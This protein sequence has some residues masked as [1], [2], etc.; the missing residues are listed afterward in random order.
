MDKSSW[1]TVGTTMRVSNRVTGKPVVSAYALS[2][3]TGP[4]KE[5]EVVLESAS[6]GIWICDAQ[7]RVLKVNPASEWLKNVRASQVVNR[8]MH[9]LLAEGY[10]DRSVTLEVLENRSRIEMLQTT[11]DG[12]R[13]SVI[14]IPVYDAHGNLFR[15]VSIEKDITEIHLLSRQLEEKEALTGRYRDQITELQRAELE[16]GKIVAKSICFVNC[17]QQA[18]KVST[19]DSTVMLLGE[20]GFRER[21]DSRFDSS[22]FLAREGT[23]GQRQFPG[24]SAN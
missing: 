6:E 3:T 17:I 21:S 13:L 12:R 4:E 24:T 18:I 11:R 23:Y 1:Q 5:L 15:V 22:Q 20:S 10:L 7:A 9:E 19:V 2:G 14:G 16:S 8:T